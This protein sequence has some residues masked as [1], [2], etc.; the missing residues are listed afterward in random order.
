MKK[1]FS[2]GRKKLRHPRC[3][4]KNIVKRG[5]G[6]IVIVDINKIH[7]DP[8][9][10]RKVFKDLNEMAQTIRTQGIINPIEIDENGQIVTGERRW[11]A[12]VLAGLKEAPCAVKAGLSK[13]E[14]LERQLVENLQQKELEPL[15][16]AGAIKALKELKGISNEEL[17]F[18]LGI[19][20]RHIYRLFKL[21]ELPEELKEALRLEQVTFTELLEI[22]KL[23]E[24]DWIP[25]LRAKI[26]GF[27]PIRIHR[28]KDFLR[29]KGAKPSIALP[30]S[31]SEEVKHF[32]VKCVL[33]KLFK[34]AGKYP[35]CEVEVGGGVADVVCNN[36]C[37]EIES[38]PTPKK[39]E[40]KLKAFGGFK[41]IF[42][43][44]LRK[45][46]DNLPEMVDYLKIHYLGVVN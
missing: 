6:G 44:D 43:I 16:R 18:G 40:K 17:A 5:K 8:N 33:Y 42:V 39:V 20:T 4:S 29:R 46:P 13:E 7:P 34:D 37:F 9:Q 32:I 28:P 38:N 14:R 25:A 15:E 11:R 27:Q 1:T 41:D 21:L 23:D 10:P 36:F 31:K 26:E 12:A 2:P 3:E 35:Q 19:S 45:V 24:K 30:T 22:A